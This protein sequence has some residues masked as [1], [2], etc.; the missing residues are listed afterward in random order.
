MA[1][2]EKVKYVIRKKALQ[3]CCICHNIGVE[4][5]HIIPQAENGPDTLENGAPLCPSCHETYGANKTKRKFI[6]EARDI[7]YEICEKRYS[8]SEKRFDNIESTLSDIKA[9]LSKNFNFNETIISQK[10]YLT[11]GEIVAFYHNQTDANE[12]GFKVCYELIFSTFGDENNKED[13]LFNEFRDVFVEIFGILLAEKVVNYSVKS[14]KIDWNKGFTEPELNSIF[15]VCYINMLILFMQL[16]NDSEIE[17]LGATLT[18]DNND[19]LYSII[20]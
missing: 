13:M 16:D 5:H 9:I 10:K 17:K 1:F 8:Y 3:R 4:I 18:E 19:L 15:N 7:W 12:I 20:K 6:K 11:F 14:S 2:T